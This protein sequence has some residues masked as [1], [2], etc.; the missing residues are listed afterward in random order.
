M[1]EKSV[2]QAPG[3]DGKFEPGA[4]KVDS[5]YDGTAEVVPFNLRESNAR[6]L[7]LG[8]AQTE[9]FDL[10]WRLYYKA[11]YF[12]QGAV[13]T[14]KEPVDGG[15]MRDPLPLQAC[16]ATR[17][18]ARLQ[19]A[20]GDDEWKL[21]KITCLDGLNYRQVAEIMFKAPTHSQ[22]QQA[23]WHVKTAY[24]KLTVE[25]GLSG[26]PTHFAR[27]NSYMEGDKPTDRQDLRE[28]NDG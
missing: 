18:I 2:K 24:N 26:T 14:T 25:L 11:G 20:I 8:P 7:R 5:P 19:H 6:T 3:F 9:A 1:V 23:T 12:R 28:A 21:V 15:G 16:E 27:L 17:E 22:V 13:D 4:R 10:V